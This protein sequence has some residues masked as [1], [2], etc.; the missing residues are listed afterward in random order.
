MASYRKYTR[1]KVEDGGTAADTP[2]VVDAPAPPQ[3]ASPAAPMPS[4]VADEGNPLRHALEAHSRAEEMQRQRPQQQ[5]QQQTLEGY[6]DGLP[7]S[8]HKKQFLRQFPIMLNPQVTPIMARHYQAGLQAGFEDD[9]EPLDRYVLDHVRRDIE[10]HQKLT[11]PTARPTPENEQRHLDIEQHA[12]DLDAEAASYLDESLAAHQPEPPPAPKRAIQ[13]SAPVSREVP[14][15]TGGRQPADRTLSAE[16]RQIARI[17]FPHLAPA[18]AE[19]E[20]LVNRKRM[21][22]MKADGRIQNGER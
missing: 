7:V 4:P 17:S 1:R 22:E 21:N 8:D 2:D 3:P 9:S 14:M 13:Y 6:I 11:S 16:E 5:P 20:Y 12:A 19:F 18:Q 15:S 10:H